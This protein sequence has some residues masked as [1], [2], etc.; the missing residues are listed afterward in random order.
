MSWR[1]TGGIDSWVPI[2]S[3]TSPGIP[4]LG[5]PTF[6]L[7]SLCHKDFHVAACTIYICAR[8]QLFLTTC[9]RMRLDLAERLHKVRKGCVEGFL[10]KISSAID[11][12]Y[13]SRNTDTP[14]VVSHYTSLSFSTQVI[15]SL[16]AQRNS[17]GHH[18]QSLRDPRATHGPVL[19]T[20]HW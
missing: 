13:A 8:K 9:T 15:R 4:L 20:H 17:V 1:A 18:K 7:E 10:V 3:C 16:V 6:R 12:T 11:S 2:N 5:K 14:S 19:Q